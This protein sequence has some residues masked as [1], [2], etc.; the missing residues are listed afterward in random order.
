MVPQERHFHVIIKV[1]DSHL[2]DCIRNH[3][4][5]YLSKPVVGEN[6]AGIKCQQNNCIFEEVVFVFF[7]KEKKKDNFCVSY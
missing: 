1:T 3:I 4:P 7:K 5:E 2:Q 6:I